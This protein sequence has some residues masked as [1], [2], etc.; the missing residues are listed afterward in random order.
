MSE[1]IIKKLF[2]AQV[3]SCSCLTKTHIPQA[4]EEDC[5]YRVLCEAIE[6]IKEA[7]NQALEDAAKLCDE[8]ADTKWQAYKHGPINGD[9]RAD[10][11]TEGLSDGAESCGLAIRSLKSN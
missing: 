4:H 11:H 1:V 10:P 3:A 8:Y 6:A 5:L 7:R 9:E 2:L